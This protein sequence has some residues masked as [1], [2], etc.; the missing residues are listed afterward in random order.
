MAEIIKMKADYNVQEVTTLIEFRKEY[1]GLIDEEEIDNVEPVKYG[2]Q[3]SEIIRNFIKEYLNKRGI[4]TFSFGEYCDIFAFPSLGMHIDGFCGPNWE[5][6]LLPLKGAGTMQHLSSSNKIVTD[7]FN[8]VEENLPNC[9]PLRL[10]DS[11]PHSFITKGI[12]YAIICDLKKAV[13]N[14]LFNTN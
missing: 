11:K 5:T 4:K 7:S 14:R 2:F 3:N 8:Q 6:L 12:C 10:N 13:L 1:C 9:R